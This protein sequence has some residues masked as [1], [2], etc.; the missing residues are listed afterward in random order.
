MKLSASYS[1]AL[2]LAMLLQSSLW[3]QDSTLANK[4]STYHMKGNS[5]EVDVNFLSNYYHQDGDHAAVTGGI[6]TEKLSD[7]ANV[8]IVNIPLDSINSVGLYGGADIYSSASTDNIDNNVSSASSSD[9]HSFATLSYN[10]KNLNRNETYGVHIGFS[11]EF[12]YTSFSAGL[13]YTREWNDGNSEVNINGQAFIDQWKLIYPIELRGDIS[14]PSAGRQSYN[15]QLNYSQVLTKRLQMGVSGEFVYMAGLLSTPFHRVYFSDVPTHSI[16]KLP[17]NRLKIPL[18]VRLNYYPMDNLVL[19]TYYRYYW[20]DFGIVGN[21]FELEV[22]IK[23]STAF[24]LSPF[25]RYHTQTASDYFAPYMKHQSTELFYTS[26]YDLSALNS[27]KFG[28]GFRIS[29]LYGLVHTKPF[30]ESQRIFSI[31][32][33]EARTGYYHR[34]TGLNSYFLTLNL[35]MALK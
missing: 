16:E 5:R 34:S 27:Q 17:N 13:S 28:L 4:R 10:R 9:V 29:P 8:L 32:Y 6:G 7:F 26:D 23:L 15:G 21:T 1:L 3:A 25:Y 33:L 22:P 11:T 14:L 20:D 35:G 12:D 30:L 24:T 19:R 18:G 2:L 31:K